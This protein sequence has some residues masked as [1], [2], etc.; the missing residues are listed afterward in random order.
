[1]PNQSQPKKIYKRMQEAHNRYVESLSC[2]APALS[3]EPSQPQPQ[4]QPQALESAHE[5]KTDSSSH[6]SEADGVVSLPPE[7]IPSPV[8]IAV[9]D[10]DA[11]IGCVPLV[12]PHGSVSP[13]LP[14]PKRM[15][16]SSGLAGALTDRDV[17]CLPAAGHHAA[18]DSE[19]PSY[20]KELPPPP[21]NIYNKGIFANIRFVS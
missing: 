5:A 12:R 14:I 20:I 9:V 7:T 4:P 17:G 10:D 3:S 21:S 16:S 1:M 11:D 8:K 18:D 6:S 15:S 13:A 19:V 2:P